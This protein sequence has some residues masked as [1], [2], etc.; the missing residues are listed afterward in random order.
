LSKG[1]RGAEHIHEHLGQ[2]VVVTDSPCQ[3]SYQ[4]TSLAAAHL[5]NARLREDEGKKMIAER[6]G[7]W[8]LL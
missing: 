1:E 4:V 6:R 8:P 7:L 2:S 5:V 3:A